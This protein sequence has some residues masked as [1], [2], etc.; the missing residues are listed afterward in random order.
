MVVTTSAY[1]LHTISQ[2][3]DV[4]ATISW[5]PAQFLS[6]SIAASVDEDALRSMITTR[7]MR[8]RHEV[9]HHQEEG[10]SF[11]HDPRQRHE[12]IYRFDLMLAGAAPR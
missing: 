10:G 12:N 8:L 3:Y 2:L 4:G 5:W 11:V 1:R 6:C 9:Y 7:H